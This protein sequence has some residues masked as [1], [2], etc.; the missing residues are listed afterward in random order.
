M[1]PGTRLGIICI[2][3]D[4]REAADF[5]VGNSPNDTDDTKPSFCDTSTIQGITTMTPAGVLDADFVAKNVP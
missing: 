1:S 5:A 3:A 4:L 2:A